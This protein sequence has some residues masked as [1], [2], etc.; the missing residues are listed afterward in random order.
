MTNLIE[1]VSGL[2][3]LASRRHIGQWH[4]KIN[5]ETAICT[6]LCESSSVILDVLGKF[7]YG[8]ATILEDLVHQEQEASKS[9]NIPEEE[10]RVLGLLRRMKE[11]ADLIEA[12]NNV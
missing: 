4:E 7:N 11:A 12:D 9:D 8:D 1:K 2:K 3:Q 10:N 6:D 5:R